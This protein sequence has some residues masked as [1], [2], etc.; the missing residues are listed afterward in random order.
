MDQSQN[1][2][3]Q[4]ISSNDSNSPQAYPAQVITK[5][6]YK[7]N[8]NKAIRNKIEKCENISAEYEVTSG[9][10]TGAMDTATFELFRSACTAFFKH[11]PTTDGR[12]IQNKSVDKHG[13]ATVQQTY[14]LKRQINWADIGYTLNLYP[15]NNKMLLNGKDVDWFMDSH[16]P[17]IHSIMVQSV[18]DEGLGSVSNYN[19]ILA[20]QMQKI[21]DERQALGRQMSSRSVNDKQ[22]IPDPESKLH[23]A[24]QVKVTDSP[25]QNKVTQ[26]NN[27]PNQVCPKCKRA[28]QSRAAL[29]ELG[30]H[31]IHYFCDRLT[32]DEVDRL[33]NDPGFIYTCK[34]CRN[35]DNTD[36]KTIATT[37]G[38]KEKSNVVDLH[39]DPCDK[40]ILP[41]SPPSQTSPNGT[42]MTAAEAILQEE[43]DQSCCVCG[44][45]IEEGENRC[46][47]CALSCHDQCTCVTPESDDTCLACAAS[48]IQ[49]QQSEEEAIPQQ[50]SQ[51]TQ[52]E[53]E[54]KA[55]LKTDEPLIV[56]CNKEKR[57]P[58]PAIA[59]EK[60]HHMT[61][62]VANNGS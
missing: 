41:K 33:S 12:C 10:I 9:G 2:D 46:G 56:Q 22:Y 25:P 40:L 31:W 34:L 57:L 55:K 11:L 14:F 52:E 54:E 8:I 26:Q 15:T 39:L 45:R 53:N 51:R 62:Q 18:Q 47:I 5:R 21:L 20:T 35:K 48:L 27:G 30:N 49:K 37:D 4:P 36:P 32:Q 44:N 58:D 7:L 43:N 28:V 19:H 38:K 42:K 1:T 59:K 29:C 23:C 17:Q 16:L 61:R 60:N 6:N 3:L 50:C 24:S 13:Q